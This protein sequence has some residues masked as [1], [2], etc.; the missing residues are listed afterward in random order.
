M[1]GLIWDWCAACVIW[2]MGS[3]LSWLRARWARR[4]REIDIEILWP[5]MRD[6]AYTLVEAR[7]VFRLHTTIDHAWSKLSGEEIDKILEELM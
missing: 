1:T 4:L 7:R 2:S 3:P 5:A 6:V